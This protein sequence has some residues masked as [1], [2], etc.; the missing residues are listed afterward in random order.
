MSVID[1]AGVETK[2]ELKT[3]QLERPE[4][5]LSGCVSK[6]AKNGDLLTYLLTRTD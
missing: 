5:V 3:D 1:W 4:L 6:C 2:K